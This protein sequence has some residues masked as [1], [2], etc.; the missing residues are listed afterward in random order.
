MENKVHYKM[1]KAGKKWIFMAITATTFLTSGVALNNMSVSAD[2]NQATETTQVNPNQS[3]IDQDNK[4]IALDQSK[5][6]DN[7]TKIDQVNQ[8][9]TQAKQDQQTAQTNLSNTQSTI[10]HDADKANNDAQQKISDLQKKGIAN[11]QAQI[12]AQI[13]SDISDYNNTVQTDENLQKQIDDTNSQITNLSTS[14]D[15]LNVVSVGVDKTDKT[16]NINKTNSLLQNTAQDGLLKNGSASIINNTFE[17]DPEPDADNYTT[18]PAWVGFRES[19]PQFENW[20]KDDLVDPNKGLTDNQKQELAILLLNAINNTRQDLGLLPFTMSQEKF[21]QAQIRAAQRSAAS[22]D[23]DKAD[24]NKDFGSEQYEN[25][26]SF[27]GNKTN[28]FD[29]YYE[30]MG[31]VNSMLNG[32]VGHRQNFLGNTGVEWAPD[33]A[34]GFHQFKD[35]WYSLT[36]DYGNT[37]AGKDNMLDV[38]NKYEAMGPVQGPNNSAKIGELR[39]QLVD[40]KQTLSNN[41]KHATDLFKELDALNYKKA[42]VHFDKSQLSSDDQR[43][44]DD[45]QSTIKNHDSNKAKQLAQA[46]TDY[47]NNVA[48]INNKIAT[49][50]GQ[51]NDY[52]SANVTLQNDIDSKKAEI[53][54]LSQATPVLPDNGDKGGVTPVQPVAPATPA[55]DN[56]GGLTPVQPVTPTTPADDNKGDVTPAQPVTPTTPADD[57]K[58]GET[59]AQPVTPSTPSDDNKGG[60]IPAQ[61]VA[62]AT[63]ADDNKGGA[64]PAQPVAPATPAD[65][66]KGGETPAQPVAPATPADNNKGGATP[67]QPVAPA[68]PADNNKGGATPAQPVA[69]ATPADN[70]KGGATP[71]QPVAPATPADNNKGGETPAQPVTPTTPADDN[72][73]GETPAQPVAPATPANSNNS[74]DT[75]KSETNS[76]VNNVSVDSHITN[77]NQAQVESSKPKVGSRLDRNQSTNKSN[78]LP[79]TGQSGSS[80][81][82]MI[83][84]VIVAIISMFGLGNLNKKRN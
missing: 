69:P 48:S 18:H 83:G 47:D 31:S 50:N 77:N 36:F 59:P 4:D 39:R 57:N 80:L 29:I 38:I 74:V 40:L 78:E 30:A 32:D 82:S 44:Y 62:P 67:A 65:N 15:N 71:A 27:H 75:S 34:F 20:L 64:I 66:N 60:A 37:S 7:N 1:F 42:N 8:S 23:H 79:Q 33:A 46:Q 6:N 14:P 63:P 26:A 19:D 2:A 3:Q 55:D 53:A 54:K 43:A 9:L 5:I 10:N 52:K 28:M 72:K 51:I 35:N 76:S 81:L 45:A 11:G 17:I 16:V 12:Q 21:N 13:K 49:L 73:G 22:L 68:T 61:P 70:N 56:K 84:M 41:D 58:G 25:L 24:M